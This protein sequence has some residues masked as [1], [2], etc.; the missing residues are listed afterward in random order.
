MHA[1]ANELKQAVRSI[2]AQP[3]FSLLVVGV[4]AAGLTAVIYM[5]IAIGSMVMRPLPFAEADRLHYI[6][7][8]DGYGRNGQLDPMR[9]ADLIGL[10]RRLDGLARVGGFG[11]ATINLSDLDRPERYDGAFISGDLFSILGTSPILGRDF[12]REDERDGAPTVVML[13]HELWESRYASDPSVIGRQ[14]RVN[15]ESAT[16]VGVMPEDFSFPRKEQIWSVGRLVEGSPADRSYTVV[17]RRA[18]GV[19]VSAIDTALA[20]WAADAA[21]VEPAYFRGLGVAMEPLN[22]LAVNHGTR[23]ILGIM[24][25]AVVLVL[26]VACANAAN[27]LLTRTLGR[28]Q[29]LAVRVALGASRFRLVMHLLT[30]SLLLTL[31]AVAIAIPLAMAAADWTERSFQTSDDGPP[32]W[33][34]FTLDANVIWMTLCVAVLTAL[35]AGLLPALRA[36]GDAMAGD[37]R[38]GTRSVAGGRFARI[39]RALVVGEVALSCALLIAVGTLVHGISAL[40]RAE[41][42]IDPAGILTARV[43]LFPSAYPTGADQVRLFDKISERLRADPAVIDVT[44]GTN[45]P[46]I[47]NYHREFLTDG[48]VAGDDRFR[49]CSSAPSTIASLKPTASK[50][51]KVATSIAGYGRLAIRSRSSTSAS[52]TIRGGRLRARSSFPPRPA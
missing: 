39:S 9:E 25:T 15:A 6:G 47:N 1:I 16:I 52:R 40:D 18:K 5:L 29:E 23:N 27:L 28:R 44:A 20:A 26:L 13:S 35:V 14:I 12:T 50:C 48:E 19:E 45:L 41:L 38:D 11:T 33:L 46:A 7:I 8:D 42:G 34:H 43:G 49:A 37:L 30:Q 32:H 17:L 22:W 31:G 24:M 4:L 51:A 3:G 2:A 10:R 21:R 36:G